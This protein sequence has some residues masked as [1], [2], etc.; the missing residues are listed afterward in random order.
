MSKVNRRSFLFGSAAAAAIIVTPQRFAFAQ[1]LTARVAIFGQSFAQALYDDAAMGAFKAELER[2]GIASS[3]VYGAW[4]GSSILKANVRSDQPTWYW[5]DETTGTP[6]PLL[7][8]SVARIENAALKPRQIFMLI[9]EQDAAVGEDLHLWGA[10]IKSVVWRLKQACDPVNPSAVF[11]YIDIIGRRASGAAQVVREAQ[12]SVIAT[13]SIRHLVDKHDILLKRDDPLGRF[14]NDYHFMETG[15][16][17][18]GFRCAQ[19]VLHFFGKGAVFPPVGTVTRASST[20]VEVT[21]PSALIKPAM[22]EGFAIRDGATVYE[23]ASLTYSWQGDTL[24]IAAPS[25]LAASAVLLHPYGNL[26][27]MDR[28]KLVRDSIGTPLKSMAAVF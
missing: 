13:S 11:A 15:N 5:W 23:A 16:A 3:I 8:E 18:L 7:N 20:T 19:Q 14:G 21:V 6:G 4:G 22:P 9:G 27:A 10:S 24:T 25:A 26:S 17:V 28:D 12:L 2:D 1:S